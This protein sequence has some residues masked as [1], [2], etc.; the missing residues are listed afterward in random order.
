M[1]ELISF[2]GTVINISIPILFA[3]LGLSLIHI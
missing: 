3:A 2:I 1:A